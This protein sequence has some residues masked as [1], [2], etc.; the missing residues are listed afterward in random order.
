MA[1]SRFSYQE[2]LVEMTMRYLRLNSV[3]DGNEEE[4][5]VVDRDIFERLFNIGVV[6]PMRLKCS[7]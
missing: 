4:V 3:L 5:A 1:Y 6:S 7:S 2:N